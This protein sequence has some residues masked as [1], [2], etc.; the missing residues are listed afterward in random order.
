M[1][2]KEIFIEKFN[3]G[4]IEN[5]GI[6]RICEYFDFKSQFDKN[7][8]RETLSK[9]CS[10]GVIVYKD[11][12]YVLFENSGLLKGKIKGNERGF[13]FLI[14]ENGDFFV[15]PKSLHGALDGDEVIAEKVDGK[16][17]STDEVEVKSVV[18]R[19]ITELVGTYH[20]QN[21][22][23]FV[24]P[25]S[26]S[27]SV[28]IYVSQKNSRG[29]KTGDKVQ[30]KIIS[31]PENKKNPEGKI[32]QI[33]GKRFD[34]KVEEMSIIINAG[35][36]L[37]F[38][39]EVLE[40]AEKIPNE[41]L[42]S[43]LKNRKDFR[44]DLTVTIDGDDS[45]DFDDAVCVEKNE[46][47][48]FTLGVHIADVSNY[49]KRN[50]A[51]DKEALSR[52]LSVYFP[53]RVIPMLPKKLSNGICSLNEGVDRLTLSVIMKIN[54]KGEVVD[55]EIFEGVI[56][57][58][59]RLT[60]STVQ[61]V[62][63]GEKTDISSNKQLVNMIKNANELKEILS[64]KRRK[65]G[66]IDLTVDESHIY[67]DENKKIHVEPRTDLDAYKI[68]EEFMILA[69]E[70]VAEY[71]FY[72]NL[73]FVYRVHEKPDGEK[74]SSFIAFLKVLG[75]NV[76]W[77][78]NTC[79][80]KDFQTL[81]ESIKGEEIYGVVNKVMLRSMQKAKYS[82]ENLGHFGLS[83]NCY[84]HFTSPIR[85][86]ADLTV[87]AIIKG[88]LH[89]KDIESSYS[90]F[91]YT[92]SDITSENEK[93]AVEVER[94]MD[95]YYKCRYMRSHI[96]EEY[97]GIISGVTNFGVFVELENTVE[98]LIKIETLPRGNYEFVKETFTLTSKKLTLSLGQKV[99][100]E[101]LGANTEDRRVEF[102][103]LGIYD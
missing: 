64:N 83:S 99:L 43:E 49:V 100:I 56:N 47:G 59:K 97:T 82:P 21:G 57:S 48:T 78:E 86:Y 66:N 94:T 65:Q 3:S 68:I 13:A 28:D 11:G 76:K 103:L 9:L 42:K 72:M 91:V 25:D 85:R 45:R 33:L 36:P 90:D 2:L 67:V 32:L 39:K 20:E 61:K 8:A 17:G 102:G 37:E 58:K 55:S 95:D 93:K 4:E 63:D 18:K 14:T 70:T 27:F 71:V 30:V 73:P 15:P 29:A 24:I 77:S 46:D 23:G 60:Y 53:E 62:L 51:L 98:G 88:I 92:V 34:L 5:L 26:G 22:F 12:R 44:K 50:T 87:H 40:E 35:L 89:G 7:I 101:V 19:G 38:P 52:S 10:E 79:H 96:G 31:Y 75:I 69:N 80:P 41:V 1:G 74:L 16:C 54:D 6:K 84:C 81:L